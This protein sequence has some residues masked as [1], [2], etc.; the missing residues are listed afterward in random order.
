[1]NRRDFFGMAGA[2]TLT[3]LNLASCSGDSNADATINELDAHKGPVTVFYEFRIA[4]PEN[5]NMLSAI[6]AFSTKLASNSDFLGIALKNVVGDS[7]MTKNYPDNL[8][9]VL[10]SAY[11]DA[12]A[13]KKLPLFYSLFIRFRSVDA[14]KT[15]KVQDWFKSTIKPMLSVYAVK[16]GVPVKMPLSLDYYEGLFKTVA[17]GDRDAIYTTEA[18]ILKFQSAQKDNPTENYVTVENHVTIRDEHTDAF[19]QKVVELLKI[20]QT[21]FRPDLTDDDYDAAIDP[22]GIGQAGAQDNKYYRKAVTTEILQN[23]SATGGT[24]NYVMHGVWQSVMDHENSH[25]D[26]RFRQRSGSVGTYIIAGPVEPFYET[27]KLLN[28]V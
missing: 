11:K 28:N 21:T 24:R 15:A 23:I 22:D 16:N 8:K 9:G 5:K 27:R 4:G 25:I 1:M 19:N 10:K 13:A 3:G 2:V 18:D 14:M 26:L 20:A 7:T 12:F 6:D 17:A